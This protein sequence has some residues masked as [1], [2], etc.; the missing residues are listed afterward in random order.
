MSIEKISEHIFANVEWD[1]GNIAC[2]NTDEGVVLVDTPMLPEHIAEWKAFVLGL[3]PK[4]IKYIINTHIHFDHIIGNYQLGGT[5]IMHEKMRENLFKENATLR[6]SFVVPGTPGRTQEQIDIQ[7][8]VPGHG[9]IC[10]KATIDKL[11]DYFQKLWDMTW[12]LT[13]KNL[14]ENDIV[15]NVQEEMFAFFDVDPEMIERSKMM[16]DMGTRQLIKEIT[17]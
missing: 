2:I 15:Q 6:E 1:G 5:L 14:P 8:V 12:E 9:P 16:F 11:S 4:G 13:A 17:S 7:T 10:T 3:N